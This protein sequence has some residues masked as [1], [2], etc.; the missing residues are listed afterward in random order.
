MSK[1]LVN[2]EFLNTPDSSEIGFVPSGAGAVVSTVQAKMQESVSIKDFGAV[3]DGL[4]TPMISPV[5]L[6]VIRMR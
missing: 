6:E 1:S 4:P 5:C 3:G 2:K